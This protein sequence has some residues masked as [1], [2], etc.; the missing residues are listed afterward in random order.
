MEQKPKRKNNKGL[1]RFQKIGI[2]IGIVLS[3]FCISIFG[4]CFYILRPVYLSGEK[5]FHKIEETLNTSI[6]DSAQNVHIIYDDWWIDDT[7]KM[8]FSLFPDVAELWLSNN[9]LCFSNL[10]ETDIIYFRRVSYTD[11]WQPENAEYFVTDICNA[12]AVHEYRI[13][14]DQ[15]DRD[16]WIIYIQ[17]YVDGL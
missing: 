4:T 15:T 7:F 3:L 10:A 16:L 1:S 6:P 9:G 5:A 14:I 13:L 12:D 2:G 17:L 11:W 8:R